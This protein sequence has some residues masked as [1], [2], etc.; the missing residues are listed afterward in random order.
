VD[1]AVA[2]DGYNPANNTYNN[3]RMIAVAVCNEAGN[4]VPSNVKTAVQTYLDSLREVNFVVNVIDPTFT[5][6]NVT[7]TLHLVAGADRATVVTAATEAVRNYLSPQS[8][9][10]RTTVRYNELIVLLDGVPGVDYV[11]T[12]SVPSGDVILPGVAALVRAGTVSISAT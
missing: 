11:E 9:D 5:Q 3:E 2:I 6:V 12:I 4:A 1:R 8:W 7:A 10:W